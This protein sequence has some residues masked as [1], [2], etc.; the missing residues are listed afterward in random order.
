V[1][2]MLSGSNA[3][4]L[5]NILGDDGE[6]VPP[7]W[8]RFLES[9]P[10]ESGKPVV[11]TSG[12]GELSSGNKQNRVDALLKAYRELGHLYANINPLG[13][14]M[15]PNLRYAWITQHGIGRELDPSSYGLDESDMDKLYDA[16]ESFPKPRATSGKL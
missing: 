10:E 14:Y 9:E 11:A 5:E 3:E 6:P 1:Q 12:N 16:P 4:W 13:S 15:P 2:E 7:Q 8:K